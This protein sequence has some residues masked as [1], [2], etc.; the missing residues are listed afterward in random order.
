MTGKGVVGFFCQISVVD[1]I[2]SSMGKG[3]NGGFRFYFCVGFGWC[4]VLGLAGL[5]TC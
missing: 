5:E 3:E 2:E 1:R 4:L